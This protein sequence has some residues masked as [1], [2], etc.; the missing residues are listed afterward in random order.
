MM[1]IFQDIVILCWNLLF[2]ESCPEK[3]SWTATEVVSQQMLLLG[4]W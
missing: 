3:C 4:I 1:M 2:N